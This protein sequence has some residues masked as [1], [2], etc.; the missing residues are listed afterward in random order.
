MT[1]PTFGLALFKKKKLKG[2]RWGEECEE[3]KQSIVPPDWFICASGSLAQAVHASSTG[4]LY[5]YRGS[6]LQA[7]KHPFV[8]F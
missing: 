6:I 7:L 3:Y 8:D 4:N 2:R 1:C 5:V